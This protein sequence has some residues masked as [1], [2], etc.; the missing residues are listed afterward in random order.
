MKTFDLI[1]AENI[2]LKLQEQNKKQTELANFL[3]VPRQTINKIINGKKTITADELNSIAQFF[4]CQLEDLVKLDDKN[5][6][7]VKKLLMGEIT[8]E[9]ARNKIDLI[10]QLSS[11]IAQ[12]QNNNR[13][14]D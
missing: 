13:K 5:E 14:N 11:I 6:C 10:I 7:S 3:N 8:N 4:S 1:V 9:K 2:K 12:Q